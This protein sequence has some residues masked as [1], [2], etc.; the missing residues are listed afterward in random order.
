MRLKE[1]LMIMGGS[2]FIHKFFETEHYY[3]FETDRNI[4]EFRQ[5][6]QYIFLDDIF[7]G[8]RRKKGYTLII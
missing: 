3:C 6:V 8:N 2:F 4:I 1:S 7:P 5:L